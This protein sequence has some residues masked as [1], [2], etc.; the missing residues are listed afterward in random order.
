VQIIGAHLVSS[1]KIYTTA[2]TVI[3]GF[4]DVIYKRELAEDPGTRN[5]L[6]TKGGES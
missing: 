2:E 5:W 1:R 6:F 4:E 3:A